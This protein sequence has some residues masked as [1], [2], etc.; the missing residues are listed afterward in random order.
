MELDFKGEV[1]SRLSTDEHLRSGAGRAARPMRTR[2][3]VRPTMRGR[4]AKTHLVGRPAH[5]CHMRPMFVVPID[6][7]THFLKLRAQIRERRLPRSEGVARQRLVPETLCLLQAS[8]SFSVVVGHDGAPLAAVAKPPG[9]GGDRPILLTENLGK[10]RVE[11]AS[12][13][14]GRKITEDSFAAVSS[15]MEQWPWM[16]MPILLMA[17]G[18]RIP[19]RRLRDM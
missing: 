16:W 19:R 17:N 18:N 15:G 5:E 4:L 14:G 11:R 1:T 3:Q 2:F 10:F 13:S 8:L 12:R 6:P 9:F 7:Q